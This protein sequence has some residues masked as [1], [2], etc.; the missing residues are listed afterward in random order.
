MNSNIEIEPGNEFA[1]RFIRNMGVL[2]FLLFLCT[3][4]SFTIVGWFCWFLPFFWSHT[5]VYVVNALSCL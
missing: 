4:I 1:R 5:E 2:F 3:S